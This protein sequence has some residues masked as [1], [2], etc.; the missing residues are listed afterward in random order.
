MGDVFKEQLVKK[1][2]S[3]K[4]TALRFGI[5]ALVVI[6]VFIC[7]SVPALQPFMI[8]IAAA[9]CF[10]AYILISRLNIEYEYVFTNGEL[11]ID[12]IYNKTSRKRMFSFTV[13]D[14]EIMAHVQDT[15]HTRDMLNI[16]ET[17]DCSSGVTG[18]NTY[19]FVTPYKGK[20]LKVIIEP[21]DM[22]I[23]A[24]STVLT[25]RKLFKKL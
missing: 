7:L 8:F 15:A 1:S 25:P 9:A 23:K 2:A 19:A 14:F 18:P 3:A 4:D 10:G 11:D 17:K 24:F 6:V 12:V 16:A 20:R 13:R 21:N 22:M 5:V